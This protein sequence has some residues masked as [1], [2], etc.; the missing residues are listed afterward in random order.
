MVAAAAASAGR[1]AWEKRK[2]ALDRTSAGHGTAD[3]FGVAR[4]QHHADRAAHRVTDD[5]GVVEVVFANV[6]RNFFRDG[7]RYR[8]VAICPDW[9][10]GEAVQ[11]HEMDAIMIVKRIR[12][13]VPDIAR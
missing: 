6:A 9:R 8:A 11:L 7:R 3:G 5:G 10:A 12:R 13:R 4:S 1:Q 2:R